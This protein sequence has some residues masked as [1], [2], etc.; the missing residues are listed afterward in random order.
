MHQQPLLS[1]ITSDNT[2]ELK[3]LQFWSIFSE[4]TDETGTTERDVA[5]MK[6]QMIFFIGYT[7]FF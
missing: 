4:V 7:P 2:N 6:R 5:I 1:I 3:V